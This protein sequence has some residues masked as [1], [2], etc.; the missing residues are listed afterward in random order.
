MLLAFVAA[1]GA[2]VA[3]ILSGKCQGS[4]VVIVALCSAVTGLAG[5]IGGY[6][7]HVG[8]KQEKQDL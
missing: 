8:G 4:D 1:V 3:L 7:M 2:V 6:S 5:S